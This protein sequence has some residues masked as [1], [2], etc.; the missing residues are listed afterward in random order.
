MKLRSAFWF[1]RFTLV[2][3]LLILSLT[4]LLPQVM[5][6]SVIVW[7]YTSEQKASLEL[8]AKTMVRERAASLDRELEGVIGALQALATSPLIDQPDLAGFRDQAVHLLSFRGTAVVMR[9]PAGQHII[10]TLQPVGA[11][12]LTSTDPDLL[13]NDAVIFETKAPAIS[14]LYIGAVTKVPFVNVGVPVIRD[15]EVRYVLSIAIAPA[16]FSASLLRETPKG[17]IG[18]ILDA[19][20]QVNR[21]RAWKAAGDGTGGHV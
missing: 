1:P 4:V 9:D 19:K 3:H 14:N 13:A 16:A 2:Q 11:A 20:M 8:A 6:G 17:W 15:D 21:A 7:R 12:A 5:L 10:N 18:V